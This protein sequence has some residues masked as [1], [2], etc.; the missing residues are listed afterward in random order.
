VAAGADV[1]TTDVSVASDRSETSA[2]TVPPMPNCVTEGPGVTD[3]GANR[4]SCCTTLKVEGGTYYRTYK[5][6]GNGPTAMADRAKVSSFWLDKYLVTVGRFRQFLDAWR[7]GYRPPMGSGKH[8]H[9]NE[10]KGLVISEEA[11]KVEREQAPRLNGE[12]MQ[13]MT[14]EQLTQELKLQQVTHLD[15]GKGPVLH[16]APTTYEPGWDPADDPSAP[17]EAERSCNDVNFMTWTPAPGGNENLPVNCVGWREAYAFCIWDGGFLPSEA[18]WEYA[19]AGGSQ[20]REYPWGSTAPGSGGLYAIYGG[21]DGRAGGLFAC[22]YPIGTLAS[23]TGVTNIAPV[24]TAMLGAGRWGQLDMVGEVEEWTLDEYAAHGACTDCVN[25]VLSNRESRKFRVIRSSNFYGSATSLRPGNDRV[26]PASVGGVAFQVGFRC[27]RSVGPPPA[28]SGP[29]PCLITGQFRSLSTAG[30]C[31]WPGQA[32]ST[33]HCAGEPTQC[34]DGYVSAAASCKPSACVDGRIRTADGVHCCWPGQAWASTRSSLPACVGVP[35]CPAGATAQG[36]KCLL[37][38]A[39]AVPMVAIPGGSFV[40]GEPADDAGWPMTASHGKV[41]LAPF[42]LDTTEVTVAAY[43]A[44]VASERCSRAS[45]GDLCNAG[46]PGRESHPINCVDWDQA[47]A[48][49]KATGKRLPTEEEWEWAA[50][51]G[52]RGWKYPWGD[53]P[54]GGQ[55]C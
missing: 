6:S 4:E 29:P 47:E 53:D 17:P 22:Y 38:F 9:L 31:C 42:S 30:H 46:Q 21:D 20:Q 39:D 5:N 13:M 55:L 26:H 7:A 25:L 1:S 45:Q 2:L 44:C 14:K 51:G 11:R 12:Q 41:T 16:A 28:Y 48:Y 35:A 8:T 49:C 19:A 50:R 52:E 32:W 43:A 37:P 10:G 54:P 27:A 33:D 23:C 40:T 15:G 3:C 18:E 24:G 34:P 36:E